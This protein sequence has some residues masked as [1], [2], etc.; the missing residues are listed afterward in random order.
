MSNYKYTLEPYKGMGTFKICPNC[1]KKEFVRYIDKETGEYLAPNVGRCNREDKC[2]YHYKPKQYFQDNNIF[3]VKSLPRE[4][5]RIEMPKPKKVYITPVDL[6][7][8]SLIGYEKNQFIIFLNNLFGTEATYQLISKYFIG[9][10]KHWD[11]ATMFWQIDNKGKVRTGKIMLYNPT[12]GKRIKKPYNH[13]AW[14]HTAIKQPDSV[15]KQCLFGEH[16]LQNNTRAVAIVE[17][18]KTAIISS[19]YFPQF[20]WLATGGK[21]NMNVE[22]F[23]VLKGRNV[24]LFP[25]L[26]GY[27]DWSKKAKEFK[28]RIIQT[29]FDVSDLLE[30]LAPEKDREEGYDIADYLIKKNWK[31]FCKQGEQAVL[32]PEYEFEP[33]PGYVPV[34]ASKP[35]P[36]PMPEP[37]PVIENWNTPLAEL[38]QFFEATA[39]PTEPIKINDWTTIID[40]K[41]FVNNSLATLKKYNGNQYFLPSLNEL[42][43]FKSLI[44]SR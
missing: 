22:K 21:S 12:T 20:I 13:I 39:L 15:L 27:D 28:S 1:G 44:S 36:E 8:K 32:E 37:E 31:E 9:T 16:L 17:S 3:F 35:E 23:R 5:T 6:F 30:K 41:L 4:I 42:I 11:G 25:D 38:V 33:E 2:G 40:T 26:K 34:I 14:A 43:K 10:S 18:E 19:M 7:K 29:R 24:V